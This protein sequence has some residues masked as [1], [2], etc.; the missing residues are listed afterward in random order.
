[1]GS[2]GE[3]YFGKERFRDLENSLMLGLKSISNVHEKLTKYIGVAQKMVDAECEGID[4]DSEDDDDQQPEPSAEEDAA[5][6]DA[7]DEEGGGGLSEEAKED[8]RRRVQKRKAKGKAKQDN[9]AKRLTSFS[10]ENPDLDTL[11]W[12]KANR[13]LCGNN[14]EVMAHMPE[15]IAGL[16]FGSPPYPC[17]KDYEGG[18]SYDKALEAWLEEDIAPVVKESARVLREG[19]RLIIQCSDTYELDPSEGK[20]K[21]R[22]K[23]FMPCGAEV[24]HLVR[25]MGLGL[26]FRE[27]KVWQKAKYPHKEPLGS[28]GSPSDPKGRATAEWIIV[29]DKGSH[30]LPPPS[31][32]SPKGMTADFYRLMTQSVLYYAP[33]PSNK[34]DHPCPFPPKLASDVIRY[35]SWHGDLVIDPWIGS[36]T[37]A[38][39]A[40]KLGRRFIGIDCVDK[41]CRLANALAHEAQNERRKEVRRMKKTPPPAPE[42]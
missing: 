13:I 33:S 2:L 24:V 10:F 35:W 37:T 40:A 19:G 18:K 9:I 29:F 21:A 31:K 3:M 11:G 25:S 6:E 20:A 39:E 14:A 28:V 30:T 36:G 8:A 26:Q 27:V 12:E 38:A 5:D 15:G 34:A 1:M 4:L 23:A 22:S 7:D 42:E 16:V 41:Y 17:P 32:S